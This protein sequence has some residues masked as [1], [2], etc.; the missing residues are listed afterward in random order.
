MTHDKS[1]AI[2][3]PVT[4]S[5]ALMFRTGGWG[6]GCLCQLRTERYV[7]KVSPDCTSRW[8]CSLDWWPI[9][10]QGRKWGPLLLVALLP[11]DPL[12]FLKSAWSS[13]CS[14][15]ACGVDID[16][17]SDA[18]GFC[19]T[20]PLLL[21]LLQLPLLLLRNTDIRLQSREEASINAAERE[22]KSSDA[23]QIKN[24]QL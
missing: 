7:T 11:V 21:L 24:T 14:L 15:T 22:K 23:T 10:P 3:L 17:W 1:V 18:L 2:E 9:W 20:P 5:G 4:R 8:P 19:T 13:L 6:N 16:R 12:S